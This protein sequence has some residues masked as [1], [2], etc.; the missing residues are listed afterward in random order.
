MFLIFIQLYRRTNHF[1]QTDLC[2]LSSHAFFLQLGFGVKFN[3][4]ASLAMDLNN[5]LIQQFL[6]KHLGIKKIHEFDYKTINGALYHIKRNGYKR[7]EF[8]VLKESF[9]LDKR[10]LIGLY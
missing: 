6:R 2:L 4:D 3:I 10:G 9:T 8:N 1:H 7:R 5:R